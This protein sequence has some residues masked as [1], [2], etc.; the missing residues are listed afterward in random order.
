MTRFVAGILTARS[1]REASGAEP[2]V[3]VGGVLDTETNQ[4]AAVPLG[5]E[6]LCTVGAEEALAA[7]V[8]DEQVGSKLIF[9]PEPYTF[10]PA[11]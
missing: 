4:V 8:Y 7:G 3:P 1:A 5:L 9:E 10:E 2:K 11:S 6:D